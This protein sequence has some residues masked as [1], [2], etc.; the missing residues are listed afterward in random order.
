M[1]AV[2]K[3]SAPP[4]VVPKIPP[5][6]TVMMPMRDGARLYTEVFLPTGPGPFPTVLLRT[7]YPDPTFPFSARPIEAFRAAGYA[8]AIQSCRGTWLSEGTFRFFQ[9]EPEDGYDCVEHLAQQAWCN[10]RI[11]MSGSSYLGSVQWLAARLRPPHLTCIAPQSPAAMFFYETPY[12]GGALFKQ[13][14]ITW[15]RLVSETSWAD[16][17]FDLDDFLSDRLPDASHPILRA[18]AESPNVD[19]VDQWHGAEMAEAMKEPLLH[20]TYDEWWERIMLSDADAGAIDIPVLAI[21]GFHDGDQAGALHNW[22]KVEDNE[23]SGAARRHLLVGPWRHSQMR[24]G[25]AA[26]MGAVDFG[27]G[28]SV[29]LVSGIVAFFDAYL[30]GEE[31]PRTRLPQRCRLFVSGTNQWHTTSAYPPVESRDTALHLS[32]GGRA[33]SLYGDGRLSFDA[34]GEEPPDR[35]VADWRTPVPV[36]AVGADCREQ[37]TRH[38]VLVYTSEVLAADLTVLGPVRADIYLSADAPDADVMVRIEDCLPDGRSINMTGEL[39]V[40]PFRARYRQGFDREVPLTPGEA[41][42]VPFHV[43]HMGHTFLA[44]HRIRVSLSATAYPA[45]EPNHHTGEPVATATERRTATETIFHDR[46]RPSHLVLPVF[47]PA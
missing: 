46:E 27:P 35:L 37:S 12:V 43:C 31:T 5:T 19:V 7:P 2:S 22:R 23:L 41:D 45:I 28:A 1:A 6:V 10:G 3:P 11:G 14:L 18:L 4:P 36:V 25:T 39:G 29:D 9:N 47:R 24:D 26:P 32:S 8:V 15:P 13:H 38:D 30:K 42:L 16:V 34:P 17:G 40:A 20:S 44:G 21:T 33:N